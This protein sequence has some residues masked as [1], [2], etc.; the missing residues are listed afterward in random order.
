MPFDQVAAL[1]ASR[2][3]HLNSAFRPT[4]NMAANLVR[5]YTS[6]RAHHLL[7]LSFAQYQADREVVR[8]EARLERRQRQLDEL[9]ERSASPYGDIDEYRRMME[10]EHTTPS[11]PAVR[12]D[13]VSLGMMRVRPGDI[14]YVEKGR[15][16]GRVAVLTNAFRKGGVKLTV[17][18]TRRDVLMLT[19]TDFDEA[20]TV[21]GRIELPADFAP[22]R[23]DYQ[24][25]VVSRLER[26]EIATP[27]RRRGRGPG[28]ESYPY[29]HPVEDDPDLQD[30]LK[31][32]AQARR[33][34]REVEELRTRMG[35]RSQSVARDFDLVLGI[36]REWGYVDGWALTDAGEVL[37]G[38]FHESD[39]L[40]VEC[41][42]RG[43][44]D[45][46]DPASLAAL[47]SVFVYEHRSPEPPP[48]RGTPHPRYSAGGSRSPRSATTCRTPRRPPASGC[49]AHPTPP[50]SRS[51][52]PGRRGRASPR[53]W[54]TRT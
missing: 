48:T 38:L 42:R 16:A 50:S 51:P 33:A 39:L 54:P 52:S 24:R 35:G 25:H 10:I 3:F 46:L 6:E 2:S 19:A 49:T 23:T 12:D 17:L 26:A 28:P 13:H 5:S 22:N 14:L 32:A 1:A 15:Y 34:A 7:N 47:A 37:A 40:V 18:T 31:A 43:L 30:R 4:Y 20:P 45:G 8:L 9:L 29:G 27:Q 41:V 44:L 21:L 53:W 36:L 11:G